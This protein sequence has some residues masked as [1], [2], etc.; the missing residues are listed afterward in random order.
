MQA[1]ALPY[2]AYKLHTLKITA[3]S[4]LEPDPHLEQEGSFFPRPAF[5]PSSEPEELTIQSGPGTG[6]G[7][8]PGVLFR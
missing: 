8:Q 1:G 5:S 6:G 2:G 4:D 7:I 3:S